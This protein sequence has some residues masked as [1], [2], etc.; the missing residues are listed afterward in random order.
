LV[1]QILERWDWLQPEKREEIARAL[2]AQVLPAG[3][4]ADLSIWNERRLRAQLKALL[5]PAETA[6]G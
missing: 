4:A 2:L 1:D 5:H 6:N 3:D